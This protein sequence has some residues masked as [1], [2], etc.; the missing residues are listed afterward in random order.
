MHPFG[1]FPDKS[2]VDMGVAAVLEALHDAG[3]GW[4]EVDALY[5]GHMYAKTGAGQRI[6]DVL[7]RTGLPVLNVENACSS[8]GAVTQLALHALRAGVY[9]HVVVVGVEKMPRGAM[10]MDYFPAWRQESGHALNPAQFAL[11][12]QRHA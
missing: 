12:A 1:R 3:V 6:V 10:D 7:G 8:G 5:C 11:A 2:A 4:N 9:R